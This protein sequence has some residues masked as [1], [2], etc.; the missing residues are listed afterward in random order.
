MS[1][2]SEV[3]RGEE[4]VLSFGLPMRAEGAIAQVQ[5]SYDANVLALVSG[6]QGGPGR[7]TVEV[8]APSI[9]GAP[10][11]VTQVRF[12]AVAKAPTTGQ[13]IVE[14]VRAAD[15]AQKPV[16]VASPGAHFVAIGGDTQTNDTPSTNGAPSQSPPPAFK[17]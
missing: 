2:P 14:N 12:R 7:A 17:Q 10:A 6:A 1:G 11:P 9:A 5:L 13:I 3:N 4:F 16:N 15:N 8:V